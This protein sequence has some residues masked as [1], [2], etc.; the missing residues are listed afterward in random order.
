MKAA[1][2]ETQG[3]EEPGDK[4]DLENTGLRESF[5]REGRTGK[6]GQEKM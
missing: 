6:R 2:S 5:K 3:S 1:S 4:K